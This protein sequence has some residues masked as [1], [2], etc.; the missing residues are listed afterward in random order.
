[1]AAVTIRIYYLALII[2]D[3]HLS[4][5]WAHHEFIATLLHLGLM[6]A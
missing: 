5:S 6:V 3:R 4:A 2:P 1:V